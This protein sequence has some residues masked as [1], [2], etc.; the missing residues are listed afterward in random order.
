M[1]DRYLIPEI[2][3][4]EWGKMSDEDQHKYNL[5]IDAKNE[6]NASKDAY[7]KSMSFTGPV[8]M[9]VLAALVFVLSP[10]LTAGLGSIAIIWILVR[11]ISRSHAY[12]RYRDAETAL[13]EAL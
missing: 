11:V 9:M 10:I 7:E 12:A 5:K 1:E 2:P 4:T 6:Y 13:K 8:I 3:D